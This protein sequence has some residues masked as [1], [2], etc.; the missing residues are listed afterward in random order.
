MRNKKVV[1]EFAAPYVALALSTFGRCD[2]KPMLFYPQ[3][4]TISLIEKVEALLPTRLPLA[5]VPS[6]LSF[7]HL[8]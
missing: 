7:N 8:R 5:F 6:P 1:I 2:S 3:I 4:Q